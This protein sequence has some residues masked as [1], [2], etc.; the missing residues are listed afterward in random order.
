MKT[1]LT[2]DE[3]LSKIPRNRVFNCHLSPVGRVM[4][5]NNSVYD[6][7]WFMFVDINV[8]DCCLSG[9]VTLYAS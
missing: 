8:F 1:L 9:V 7:F 5:I 4:A 3:R 2:I 6:S